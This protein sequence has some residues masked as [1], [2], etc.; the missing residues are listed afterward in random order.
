MLTSVANPVGAYVE[1]L[2][3]VVGA[4]EIARVLSGLGAAG[5]Q[6]GPV[7]A[8]LAII[9]EQASEFGARMD[10]VAL[11]LS[12]QIELV[13]DNISIQVDESSLSLDMDIDSEL[14]RYRKKNKAGDRMP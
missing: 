5:T 1:I 9:A 7:I 13:G 2:N 14:D 6:L 3:G 8:E 4:E 12:D 11:S 10:Q